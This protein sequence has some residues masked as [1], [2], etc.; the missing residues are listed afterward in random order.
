MKVTFQ[1][2]FEALAYDV[3]TGLMRCLPFGLV[4]GF[5]AGLVKLIGPLTSK[6]HIVETGL[7]TARKVGRR[8]QRIDAG[9][10][11]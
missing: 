6:R 3:V 11:G 8:D 1:D 7:R 2:R 5:G 9:T 10:V 4:S